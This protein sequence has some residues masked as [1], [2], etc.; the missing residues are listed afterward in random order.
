[1]MP[2]SDRLAKMAQDEES[3]ATVLREDADC[4]EASSPNWQ[5]NVML[6]QHHSTRAA[7]YLAAAALLAKLEGRDE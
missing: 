2:D 4:W 1:M 3:K 5:H 6:S 7:V